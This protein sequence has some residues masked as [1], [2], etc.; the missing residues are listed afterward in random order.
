MV[1]SELKMR[2]RRQKEYRVTCV[3]WKWDE[4]EQMKDNPRISQSVEVKG[5]RGR[6]EENIE[7]I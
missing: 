7:I 5:E 3:F 6:V 4:R 2:Q 1:T